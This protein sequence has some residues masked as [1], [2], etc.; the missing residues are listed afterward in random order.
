MFFH[1]LKYRGSGLPASSVLPAVS[2]TGSRGILIN[3]AALDGIDE[4]EVA[5]DPRE[6]MSFRMAAALDVERGCRQVHA[7]RDAADTGAWRAVDPVQTLDPHC[8]FDLLF[9]QFLLLL[10]R[11]ALCFRR[12][13]PGDRTKP[14]IEV[15]DSQLVRNVLL[16]LERRT[17]SSKLDF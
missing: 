13:T 9:L 1:S 10:T 8:S 17:Q 6:G 7:E 2:V 16:E 3:D 12:R 5:D 4:A 14:S 11:E 15:Q